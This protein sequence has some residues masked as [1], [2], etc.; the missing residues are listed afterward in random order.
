MCTKQVGTY[1][2]TDMNGRAKSSPLGSQTL[3]GYTKKMVVH[4]KF[5]I[6]IP[7]GY[8]LEMAGPVMCAGVTMYDPLKRQGATAGTRVGIIGLGGLGLTGIKIAKLMGCTVTAISRTG[9]EKA[10]AGLSAGAV[11]SLCSKDAAEMAAAAGSLDLILT[12]PVAHDYRAYEPL[13]SYGGKQ[14]I[15][16]VSDA[17]V[18]SIVG[19][20]TGALKSRVT[21][22]SGIGGIANTQE[23]L[24]FFEEHK[25]YPQVEIHPVTDLNS[26]MEKLD[27]GNESSIRYV[28]D[29]STLDEGTAAKCTAP[30][31]KMAHAPSPIQ[32]GG[33]L[34]AFAYQLL[35]GKV[36]GAPVTFAALAWGGAL[37]GVLALVARRL[38]K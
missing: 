7:D 19:Q 12:I 1:G 5:A 11:A 15:L 16:G 14:V 3:G 17:F 37:G 30:P 26:I 25:M 31:A 20:L 8:P 24:N 22:G 33:I 32:P 29:F 27:Q 9:S 18:A 21:I 6:K 34:K 28:L 2:F 23:V 13:V 4:E 35:C 38:L 10:R 36:H